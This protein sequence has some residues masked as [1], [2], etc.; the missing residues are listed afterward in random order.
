MLL[1]DYLL[2]KFPCLFQLWCLFGLLKLSIADT[3]NNELIYF[4]P[5]V[6]STKMYPQEKLHL[7]KKN[8]HM[9]VYV[10]VCYMYFVCNSIVGQVTYI[11]ITYMQLTINRSFWP[12]MNPVNYPQTLSTFT[13][14]ICYTQ[15]VRFCL[16]IA[17][18]GGGSIQSGQCQCT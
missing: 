1:R 14:Q 8:C 9:T 4:Q 5:H 7:Y 12:H 15:V 11:L 13:W 16:C 10:T 6:P 17:A 2:L 3:M 18:L